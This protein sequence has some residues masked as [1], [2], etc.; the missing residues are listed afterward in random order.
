MDHIVIRY[1]R[2]LMSLR[3]KT[4]TTTGATLCSG[5]PHPSIIPHSYSP[6]GLCKFHG[7]FTTG[8]GREARA[9]CLSAKRHKEGA[10]CGCS[11]F[12]A[13]SVGYSWRWS[14]WSDGGKDRLTARTAEETLGG[15]FLREGGYLESVEW[16]K[17][18]GQIGDRRGPVPPLGGGFRAEGLETGYFPNP[19]AHQ[20][21][22]FGISVPPKRGQRQGYGRPIE[23]GRSTSKKGGKFG[24]G[25]DHLVRSL[26]VRI[27]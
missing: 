25:S 4:S 8:G 26:S 27:R 16:S 13:R 20:P 23:Y 11:V 19:F 15:K 10:F 2:L 1:V 17:K 9:A 22:S 7:Q 21:C 3:F 12:G 18:G 6:G 5:W 14:C 24:G